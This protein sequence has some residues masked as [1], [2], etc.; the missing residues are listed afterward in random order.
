M[1]YIG[2]KQ[3][4]DVVCGIESHAPI[5][6][7]KKSRVYLFQWESSWINFIGKDQEEKETEEGGIDIA[8]ETPHVPS[9]GNVI[10]DDV[11]GQDE[12][13]KICL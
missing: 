3:V 4:V 6:S 9:P 1:T 11:K 5:P 12:E 2:V 8:Q 10:G 13:H 7:A